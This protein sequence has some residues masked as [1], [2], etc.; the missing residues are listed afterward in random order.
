MTTAVG[1]STPK[2][3]RQVILLYVVT[4]SIMLGGS[5]LALWR[6]WID[7]TQAVEDKLVHD[8]GMVSTI[9]DDDLID[10]LKLLEASKYQLQQ[11]DYVH[12]NEAQIHEI[13]HKTEARFGIDGIEE[14]YGLLFFIDQAGKIRARS[15]EGKQPNVNVS[16]RRYFKELTKNPKLKFSIGNFVIGRTS[17]TPVFHIAIPLLDHQ[18]Q[19]SGLLVQQLKTDKLAEEVNLAYSQVSGSLVSLLPDGLVAFAYPFDSGATLSDQ[20]S[21]EG[22]VSRV[23]NANTPRGVMMSSVHHS[24]SGSMMGYARSNKFGLATI[25][26][27]PMTS[28]MSDFLKNQ[29]ILLIYI[30]LAGVLVSALFYLF[31]KKTIAYNL[32]QVRS[33]H[34]AL[35]G[36]HNR[37]GLDEQMPEMLRQAQREQQSVAVLFIDI[38]HF[39]EFNDTLGHEAG[40]QV[41]VKLSGLLRQA[42]QRP[43]DFVCRWGGEEFVVILPYT[44]KDGA[45]H[46]AERIL[47]DVRCMTLGD[48]G[49]SVSPPTVSI[50]LS[51][52]K[53]NAANINE[54]LVGQADRAMFDAKRHGRNRLVVY[55]D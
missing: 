16:D 8:A 33:V 51:A 39:K 48:L 9:I 49:L 10:A 44:D 7:Q 50:G 42:L 28:V 45:T 22:V 47:E 35:T 23:N 11:I 36:L 32:V 14:V 31:Y 13:L 5:A 17:G 40:D 37:W 12:A 34:D 19:L 25:V 24:L 1:Q 21:E 3:A 18:G 55:Q 26:M 30:L 43:L 20:G 54:D 41:L 27:L 38:D 6:N 29:K 4:V 46:V 15:A 52:M 2:K 53:V